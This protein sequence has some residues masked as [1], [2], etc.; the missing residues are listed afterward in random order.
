MVFFQF[1]F[2]LFEV[3]FQCLGHSIESSV[4][5]LVIL[6]SK[7]F[8]IYNL[9]QT[10]STFIQKKPSK[11]FHVNI[12]KNGKVRKRTK[13]YV[14][15]LVDSFARAEKTTR[16]HSR[17]NNFPLRLETFFSPPVVGKKEKE[18]IVF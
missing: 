2:Y 18:K 6:L 8:L 10:L 9:F 11:N 3:M 7:T 13:M 4:E 14:H 1:G 5:P 16:H 17:N 15:T 12:S